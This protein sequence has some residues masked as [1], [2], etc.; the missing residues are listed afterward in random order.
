MDVMSVYNLLEYE[1]DDKLL[2]LAHL[3]REETYEM[4]SKR[5]REC[6]YNLIQRR[7]I[8]NETRFRVYFQVSQLYP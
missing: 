6:C 3:F 8:D 4:Y 2:L 7:L 1:A 5:N